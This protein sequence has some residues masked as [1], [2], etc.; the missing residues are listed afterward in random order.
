MDFTESFVCHEVRNREMNNNQPVQFAIFGAGGRGHEFSRWIQEHPESGRL[1][2]VADPSPERRK[3]IAEKHQLSAGMQFE[4][5]ENMLA[6]PK[7]ADAVI[8]TTMDQMHASSSLQALQQG[9]HLLLEK[10][11]ATTL[12][13][14][15]A[16]DRAQRKNNRIVS[17]CHSLRH[18]GVYAEIKRILQMGTL[19]RLVSFDQLEAVEH[20]HHSHSFVRGNWSTE[21]RSSFML[22]AKSCHDIDVLAYLVGTPCLR[23]SSFGDLNYFRKENAPPGAPPRCTDGCPVE[24]SCPYSAY[25][26]YLDP[27]LHW[28][29]PSLGYKTD[30]EKLEA[31]K[32]GPFG[33][34]VFHC[35]NDV[36]DHQ[37]VNFEFE[38]GVT[39]T[40]TMTAFTHDEGRSI[41]LHGTRGYLKAN[42]K[43]RMIDVCRFEDNAHIRHQIAEQTGSHGGGDSNLMHNFV[44]AIR[45][46]DAAAVLTSASQSLTSHKIVFAAER[47]RREKR[48]VELSE[49]A[50]V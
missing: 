12:E 33:R 14:C 48:V 30:D 8:N 43:T 35:D 11:M 41:R 44:Q 34:C 1:V 13:D 39:G 22:L 37:V 19:G 28:A 31:L 27:K 24:H 10:P 42:L 47:A 40:F 21:S 3:G 17:V 26:I 46:N 20:I 6:Q 32:T 36:V 16:I 45:T 38:D 7:L 15:I 29:W 5:W 25:K 50:K 18:N 2:A 4:C 23:V 49:L 9:Y